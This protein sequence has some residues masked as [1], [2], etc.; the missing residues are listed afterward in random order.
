MRRITGVRK[1]L[2]PITIELVLFTKRDV[3]EVELILHI[4]GRENFSKKRVAFQRKCSYIYY[5]D[6]KTKKTF[7]ENTVIH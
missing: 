2:E 1:K 5:I 6:R 7:F 3:L 4:L